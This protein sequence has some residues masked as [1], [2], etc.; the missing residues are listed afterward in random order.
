MQAL[1]ADGLADAL[2]VDARR[3][4]RVGSRHAVAAIRAAG[5]WSGGDRSVR[6]R[7]TIDGTGVPEPQSSV[8]VDAIALFRGRGATATFGT[9]AAVANVDYRFPLW[10]LERGIN[11]YPAF[12]RWVHGAA[13]VDAADAWERGRRAHP[14]VAVGFELSAD[15]VVGHGLPITFASG[16]SWRVDQSREAATRPHVFVRVGRAF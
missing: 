1:G 5:A 2:V 12:I 10:R 3:Y 14:K 6:P 13:F 7:F 8:D 9:R 4:V 16:V 11:T 15:L